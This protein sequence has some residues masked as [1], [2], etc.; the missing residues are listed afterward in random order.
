MNSKIAEAIFNDSAGLGAPREIAESPWVVMKFGGSSVSTADNWATI[1]ALVKRRLDDGLKPVVVHSALKGVSNALEDLLQTAVAGDPADLL[2]S[3]RAQHYELAFALGL[4]G[5][6]LLDDTLHELDQLVAGVRLVKEVSVRVRVRIMALGEIM[7]TRLGAEF[8][9]R[10]GLPV[11]WVDARDFLVGKSMTGRNPVNEQLSATCD[12]A[13]DEAM[14]SALAAHGKVILTQGFIARN[15]AGA[16][17]LLGRGGSDTS[18]AY[19]AA[20]LGA[21]RLEIWTDVPGMFSAD[22]RVV[23]SARLLIALHYDEAQELASAGS[24]VLHPRCISPLRE[25][26]IPLFVRSTA[27]PGIAGTVVSSVTDEVEPQVK[28]ICIRNG[29][30]LI[31]MDTVGMWQEV[32]FLA[33]AFAAFSDN[34]VSVDLVSTSET[35]VTVSIDTSDG[36]LH[37]DVE[38]SLLHD[39]EKLC[40]VR[41]ISNCSAVSLVGRKIRTIIP[42]LAPALEVFEEERIHLMSQAA[43]DLNLSFVV[44][45]QQGPRL[46]SKLHASIMQREG[47][48][49]VFGASWERLFAA[50]GPI[51]RDADT[52]WMRKRDQ[53]LKVA[54]EEPNAYVYDRES[55]EQ[56]AKSLLNLKSVDRILYAVKA[57]F[58]ADLLRVLASA[59]VDFECV[60]PGEVTWLEE[61]F[62]DLDRTRILFT[63]NFAPREEYEWGL[64]KGLQVTLDNL[65]PL[66]A[67]PELFK[68]QKLFIRVDPGQGRGHH[69]HVKTAGVHSK[70]GVPRFEVDELVHLVDSAGAEVVGIHAHS[71]SGILDPD[72]WRSVAAE[73]VQIA[74]RFPSV[75]VIDLGGGLGVPEKPGDKSFDLER[76]DA[77][78]GEIRDAYPQYE[79]WLEPGRFLVARAGVLLTR[80]TQTKGKGEMRYIGVGTGMNSLIRPA[81]Y[82]AYHEIV[83]LSRAGEAPSETVT[84]VGPICETGDRLG[85]DRLLPPTREGD[86]ILVANA[87]AYGYVMSSHYNRREVAKEIVI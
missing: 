21:R 43:N 44:D 62:P 52:W 1:A 37:E 19:F 9:G 81:L 11:Q 86:I 46:V 45:R 36:M 20:I 16:T 73:L 39:L 35:N 78:L 12:F 38:A 83:N 50:D 22:P 72:N 17:V 63:P 56:A 59:G 85:S 7:S 18:A 74:E 31:S 64:K 68:D 24:T 28:G 14:Q 29:L 42:R 15:P 33:K 58:N 13:P 69:E 82:G 6:T 4:D 48:S 87:G 61:I 51:V 71:G 79:L 5:S 41:V 66:Q 25:Y 49:T 26:G 3:I 34:G 57:N 32:G 40:R 60:S 76:L 27:A 67:W 77:V 80:V 75:T 10:A 70:F 47:A 84:V 30:T 65:Y 8:L 2:A 53:L 23:P 55:V 54:G